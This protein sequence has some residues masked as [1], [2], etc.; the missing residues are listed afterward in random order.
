[1]FNQRLHIAIATVA[2]I[3]VAASTINAYSSSSTNVAGNSKWATMENYRYIIFTDGTSFYAK[4]G[5]T[6]GIDY[7]GT[8]AVTVIQNVLD[9]TKQGTIYIREGVYPLGTTGIS[10]SNDAVKVI[11]AGENSTVLTYTGLG[12]AI[13]VERLGSTIARVGIEKLGV[14][15]DSASS[16]AIA[17]QGIQY[18]QF[19]LRDVFIASN[20]G[21]GLKLDGGSAWSAYG[22]FENVRIAG[23]PIKGV[24]IVG[25]ALTQTTII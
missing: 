8:L 17:I 25:P 21:T 15:I 24:D 4:N 2:V 23:S 14:D 3:L 22:L 19:T 20:T 10:I 12:A 18:S 13:S 7:S 1:M 6:G 11:G 16:S 5:I 9:A